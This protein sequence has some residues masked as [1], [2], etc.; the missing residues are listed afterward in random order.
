L[1]NVDARASARRG[2]LVVSEWDE[3]TGDRLHVVLDRRTDADTLEEALCVLTGL[4]FHAQEREEGV[5]IGTQGLQEAFGG[6]G[7][8]PWSE[9]WRWLAEAQQLASD[10]PPPS[11]PPDAVQLGHI[12][13]ALPSPQA[14]LS[15]AA[16]DERHEVR[17]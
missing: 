16:T 15:A 17:V 1:R 11:A 2:A 8:R 12:Q 3:D 13:Q 10:E 4:A 7:G 5:S 6:A 14:P 9:L